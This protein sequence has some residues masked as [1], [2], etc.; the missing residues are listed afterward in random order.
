MTPRI[1]FILFT[2]CLFSSIAHAQ[3]V[4]IAT[5][6]DGKAE[7]LIPDGEKNKALEALLNN[8]TIIKQ[9]DILYS[10][11]QEMYY[12]EG[13]GNWDGKNI[14]VAIS[15]LNKKSQLFVSSKKSC[16]HQCETS[17]VNPCG[18]SCGLR[19]LEN[20]RKMY[21]ACEQAD[22]KGG[23]D[24]SITVNMRIGEEFAAFFKE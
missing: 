2:I 23:C 18:A 9:S 17:D 6:S 5:I 13:K 14:A 11:K 4:K 24:V 12:W 8:G 10:E 22:T 19:I 16:Y 7:L 1:Y 3:R 21:C 15:L 20:C